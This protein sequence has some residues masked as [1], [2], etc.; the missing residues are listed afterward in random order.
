LTTLPTPGIAH[1]LA[2]YG[3]LA[4]VADGEAGLQV[5]NYLAYDAGNQPPSLSLEADFP[6][7]PAMAEEGKLVEVTALASDDVQVARVQFYVNGTLLGTDGNFPFT[8]SFVTP[9]IDPGIETNLF[10][11]SARAFDTGGNA[12]WSTEYSVRLVP[13]ATPPRV[14]S[15][16]PGAGAIVGST[17]TVAAYFSEAIDP[18]TANPNTFLLV[19]AGADAAFGTADDAILPGGVLDYRGSIEAVFLSM[20]APLP[21]GLYGVVVRQP[22]A[23]LAG[24]PITPEAVWTFWVLGQTDSDGDGV[25][26]NVEAALGLDPNNPDTNG[27]GV[28]DGDEDLD[29]DRLRT[30][31]EL[32]FGLDPRVADTDQDGVNDDLEDGDND[33]LANFGE[34]AGG[35]SPANADS[36]GDG[37]DDNGETADGTSP[38]DPNSTPPLA[39]R[40]PLASFL[41]ALAQSAPAGTPLAVH[42]PLASFLNAVAQ[43]TP[44]GTPIQVLSLPSSYLNAVAVVASPL[45]SFL[46]ALGATPPEGTSIQ[47]L[48][49]QASYL[50]A[51]SVDYEG[52]VLVPS[53]VVSYLNQ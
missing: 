4:Y 24:N 41:N 52:P 15:K 22:L 5:V 33:G 37:W 19:S 20:S 26:D 11:L 47:I 27:N 13:D 32:V 45:A 8:Q 43:T 16:F 28:L 35:S 39:V 42:S 25:P 48:S 12:T 53:P 44:A 2:L 21:P 14:R 10:T 23:D 34:Q 49:P 6:L 38:A 17:D 9:L 30:S 46:N 29:R 51:I 36:D 50:N 40:S 1:A 7:D 3:G 31:W 18:A